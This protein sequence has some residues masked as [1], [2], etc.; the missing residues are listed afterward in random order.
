MIKELW[1][2]VFDDLDAKAWS[3]LQDLI[4]KDNEEVIDFI[5][6]LTNNSDPDEA[7]VALEI[8]STARN[9]MLFPRVADIVNDWLDNK[10]KQFSAIASL[11]DLPLSY[12]KRFYNKLE[13]LTHLNNDVARA[14]SA[15]LEWY[16]SYAQK[17]I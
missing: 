10:E 12:G 4:I 17:R 3:L 13:K 11:A 16:N 5:I 14:A 2:Q 8:L 6:T 9:P 15:Y 7:F 1:R